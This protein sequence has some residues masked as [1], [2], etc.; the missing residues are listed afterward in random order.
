MLTANYHTHTSRCNHAFGTE[1]E[2]ILRA[3]DAGLEV[4]GFSDHTPYF[5]DA[6]FYPTHKMTMA[7]MPDYF[8]TLLLL[9]G[10]YKD[11]IDIK[12]GFETEYFSNYFDRLIK[13]YKS[14]P[15]DYIILGQHF[16]GNEGTP[17]SF[18]S[19]D[20]TSD[21]SKLSRYTAEC[22]EAL[23][24][25]RFSCFAH[26]DLLNFVPKSREDEEFL[27]ENYELLIKAAIKTETPVEIN[28]CGIRNKRNYPNPLFWSTAGKLGADVI[29]GCDA[30]TIDGICN[31]AELAVAKKIIS[32]NRLKVLDRLYLKNPLF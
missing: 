20:P 3:I 21:R 10:K 27:I 11:K 19:F 25:G 28:L 18:S 30:H 7:E 29:V 4:L 22:I 8:N 24:T 16:V 23:G 6:D 5:Y 14:Y 31:P 2:F 32:D 13:E 1:E 9:K 12:I 15:V 26:P 17:G